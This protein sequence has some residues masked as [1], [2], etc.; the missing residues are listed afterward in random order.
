MAQEGVP[1]SK[2]ESLHNLLAEVGV[3]DLKPLQQ[4]AVSYSSR[5]TTKLLSSIDGPQNRPIHCACSSKKECE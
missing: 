2:F 5:Y 3:P 1:L 4:K